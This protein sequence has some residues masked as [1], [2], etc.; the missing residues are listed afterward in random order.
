MV[1]EALFKRMVFQ[2]KYTRKQ[3]KAKT[4]IEPDRSVVCVGNLKQR[5]MLEQNILNKIPTLV[6]GPE[7]CGKF[8]SVVEI[9]D[10]YNLDMLSGGDYGNIP[11]EDTD[12]VYIFRYTDRE[13][14]SIYFGEEARVVVLHTEKLA[15]EPSIAY[16]SLSEKDREEYSRLSGQ[17]FPIFKSVKEEH[18]I[19]DIVFKGLRSG[20]TK[21]EMPENYESWI[22]YNLPTKQ[23]LTLCCQANATKDEFMKYQ[24]L[25]NIRYKRPLILDDPRRKQYDS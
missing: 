7:C 15:L 10:K 24:M 4:G 16:Q 3:I 23:M 5:K 9:C 19:R 17:L 22:G 14:L 12:S 25:K 11:L 20:L 6:Y 1:D 13:N 18:G 2:N 21:D 8:T